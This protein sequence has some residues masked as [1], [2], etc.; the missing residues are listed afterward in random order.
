MF[1]NNKYFLHEYYTVSKYKNENKNEDGLYLGEDFLAVIDGT[2]SKSEGTLNGKT[3]GQLAR[4]IIIEI[5]QHL[6]GTEE[7]NAVIEKI[8]DSIVRFAKEHNFPNMSAS[9]V[10][11]SCKKQEIWSVGDC[12][13]SINGVVEKNSKRVDEVFA[14]TRSI[15]IH[16]LLAQ[17]YTEAELYENDVARQYLLPFLKIQE[18]LQNKTCKYGYCVFNG[19]CLPENFPIEN[20]KKVKV[21]ENAEIVLASDG[22][23]QLFSTL[24]ES[25]ERLKKI[26]AEDPF[27]YKIY[28][29]TKG[30]VIGNNSFDDRTYLRFTIC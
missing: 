14:E 30:L 28:R 2:T 22:Y 3:G 23:P 25:E 20:I 16:A 9:A 10:I 19:T 8:Q 29:S 21:P 12:Q 15:A 11:Y 17:G 6:E 27:C 7:C 24:S 13:F 1:M 5:L 4:D 18:F 26:L